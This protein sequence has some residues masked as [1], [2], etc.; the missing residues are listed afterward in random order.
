METS[1][2]LKN[3]I[4]L[5]AGATSLAGWQTAIACAR[6]GGT[7]IAVNRELGKLSDLLKILRGISDR[8]HVIEKFDM[9][10][11]DRIGALVNYLIQTYGPIDGFVHA[12]GIATPCS[13][14][15]VTPQLLERLFRINVVSAFEFI[16]HLASHPERADNITGV[17]TAPV[18]AADS[19][20]GMSAYAA[21]RGAIISSMRVIA[22]ELSGAHIRLN[23]LIPGLLL[24]EGHCSPSIGQFSACR[25]DIPIDRKV[26]MIAANTVELLSGQYDYVNGE[27]VM[28]DSSDSIHLMALKTTEFCDGRKVEAEAC[29]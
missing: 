22:G 10:A 25:Q 15:N 19:V 3:K 1:D 27:I 17:F 5:I 12:P 16:K 24:S 14:R 7:V 28:F 4:I 13:L 11:S 21:C 8:P 23:Y 20:D 9:A 29:R 26:E 6:H 18:S 2:S